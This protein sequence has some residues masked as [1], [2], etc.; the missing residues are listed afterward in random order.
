MAL[1]R[2]L[3]SLLV[4][5]LLVAGLFGAGFASAGHVHEH[6]EVRFEQGTAEAIGS[7]VECCEDTS[8][9]TASCT[10]VLGM[11]PDA[12]ELCPAAQFQKTITVRPVGLSDGRDPHDLLDPPRTA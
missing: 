1:F 4:V 7:V 2:T 9:R 8:D 12:P 5:A 6:G 10:S 11:A 3:C